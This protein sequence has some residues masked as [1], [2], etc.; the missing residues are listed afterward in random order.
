VRGLE[1]R[2]LTVDQLLAIG[3]HPWRR[4]RRRAE[5]LTGPGTRPPRSSV[6]LA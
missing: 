6:E 2:S 3:E 5:I 4:R 1:P